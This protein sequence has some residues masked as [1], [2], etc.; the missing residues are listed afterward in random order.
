L[1][2]S[3]TRGQDL[4]PSSGSFQV[5]RCG[6][7]R[8][9]L[10]MILKAKAR[11]QTIMG[12]TWGRLGERQR[13]I[14][15]LLRA[16]R[17]AAGQNPLPRSLCPLLPLMG[18]AVAFITDILGMLCAIQMRLLSQGF[19]CLCFHRQGREGLVPSDS[20]GAWAREVVPRPDWCPRCF[21]WRLLLSMSATCSPNPQAPEAA[22]EEGMTPRRNDPTQL[23]FPLWDS[24]KT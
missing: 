14:P 24:P 9:D 7:G 1:R 5:W 4:S 23:S 11:E 19:L 8:Q 13:L 3:I 2:A 16:H 21:P 6:G 17:A 12:C 18:P 10:E 15:S 20:P 22:V